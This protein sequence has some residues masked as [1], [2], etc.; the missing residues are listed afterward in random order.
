MVVERKYTPENVDSLATR[1]KVGVSEYRSY[2]KNDIIFQ[3][4]SRKFGKNGAMPLIFPLQIP[5][6]IPVS[7]LASSAA[8]HCMGACVAPPFPELTQAYVH[9]SG[10]FYLPIRLNS[11]AWAVVDC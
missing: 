6:C 10:N 11:G 4:N 2:D 8:E 9:Q 7:A 5:G 3:T 1:L